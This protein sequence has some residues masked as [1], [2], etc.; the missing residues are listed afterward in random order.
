MDKK[1]SELQS[2]IL[3]SLTREQI[4]V[5]SHNGGHTLVSAVAGSGKTVTLIHRILFLLSSGVESEK[6][7]VVM[8][9]RDVKESFE[10]RLQKAC[11]FFDLKAPKIYTYHSLGRTVC[12][13]LSENGHIDKCTYRLKDYEYWPDLQKALEY[14][15]KLVAAEYDSEELCNL[16]NELVFEFSGLI[17]RWKGDLLLPDEVL[18]SIDYE[19]VPWA[20]KKAYGKFEELRLEARYRTFADMIYDPAVAIRNSREVNNYIGNRYEHILIDEYQDI[21]LAQQE[22]IQSIAGSKASVMAVGD[23]DQCIYEWRGSRS[24]YMTGLFEQFFG[25]T[26]RFTLSHTF[27]FGHALSCVANTVMYH[28]KNRVKKYCIS[29]RKT[30]RTA[31]RLHLRPEGNSKGLIPGLVQRWLERG[32]TLKDIVILVRSWAMALEP[33]MELMIAGIPYDLADKTKSYRT[34]PEIQACLGFMALGGGH[35]LCGIESRESREQVFTAMLRYAELYLKKLQRFRLISRLVESP[36]DLYRT[37]DAACEEEPALKSQ[38]Q[39]VSR[40]WHELETRV[41]PSMP[42]SEAL[43]EIDKIIDFATKIQKSHIHK[44]YANDALRGLEVLTEYARNRKVTVAEL[45]DELSKE[46][47]YNEDSSDSDVIQITSI[48]KAK[49]GEWPMVILPRLEEGRFPHYED[50]ADDASIIEQERRL[51]YV[52]I[53]RAS[54]EVNLIAPHDDDLLEWLEH[55][56][57]G[58]PKNRKF[59]ASRFLYETNLDRTNEVIDEFYEKKSV[60]KIKLGDKEFMLRNYLMKAVSYTKS[61]K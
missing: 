14:A 56:Y 53:T 9:N 32:G 33:E 12:E 59:T 24:D 2:K 54:K 38:L 21:N 10:V 48:H 18:G 40:L 47:A 31:I 16:G 28:N 19:N 25:A 39:K 1:Y 15:K 30:P 49:G 61:I 57:W 13:N 34:R 3:K 52:A 43:I 41:Y 11:N 8:Y 7:L 37:L 26:T 22:L 27:R 44:Q 5:V 58:S 60:R 6:I 55:S 42:A 20:I 17:E 50:K 51:F 4:L 29:S 46:D 36:Q 35:G 45:I 23:E